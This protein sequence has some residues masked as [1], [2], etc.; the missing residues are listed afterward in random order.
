MLVKDDGKISET[1][2]MSVEMCAIFYKFLLMC[3]RPSSICH[4]GRPQSYDG[5]CPEYCFFLFSSGFLAVLMSEKQIWFYWQ[6][7]RVCHFCLCDVQW[8]LFFWPSA[9][10]REIS[11][12]RMSW[13]FHSFPKPSFDQQF[14]VQ[15]VLFWLASGANFLRG[16]FGMAIQ[17]RQVSH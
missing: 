17:P 1:F 11:I 10:S 8:G 5:P 3:C 2:L 12:G 9:T 15:N 7:A 16:A 4:T 6:L 13:P 14:G